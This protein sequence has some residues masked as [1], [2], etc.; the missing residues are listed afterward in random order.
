MPPAHHQKLSCRTT[1]VSRTSTLR[2]ECPNLHVPIHAVNHIVCHLLAASSSGRFQVRPPRV[3]VLLLL[4]FCTHCTYSVITCT[5]AVVFCSLQAR[6][7]DRDYL[8][9]NSVT[10][11]SVFLRIP[12]HEMA[13]EAL[14]ALHNVNL[15]PGFTLSVSWASYAEWKSAEARHS[16]QII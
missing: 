2:I 1:S 9:S 14:A 7:V 5:H 6:L 8:K 12:T 3:A 4:C 10:N 15:G 11:G 16:T 13:V